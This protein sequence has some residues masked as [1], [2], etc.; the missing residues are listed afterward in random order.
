[1][2]I[3]YLPDSARLWL[4]T[5]GRSLEDDELL[6]VE[7]ALNEFV[8]GW[9]SHNAELK[10][11]FA[12]LHKTVVAIAVDESVEAPSGCSIDKAFRLLSDLGEKLKTNFLDRLVVVKPYCNIAKV[13][14]RENVMKAREENALG[15]HDLVFDFSI[16]QLGQLRK[17]Y[18]QPFAENWLGKTLYKEEAF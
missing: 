10:A 15:P 4:F 11:G 7:T 14:S 9:K 18:L 1:M 13:M 6:L 5:A 17:N 2:M 8:G 3:S 16:N 12:I